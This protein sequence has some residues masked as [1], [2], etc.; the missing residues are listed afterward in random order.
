MK[1]NIFKKQV[2]DLENIV[3]TLKQQIQQYILINLAHIYI[4][5]VFL[6]KMTVKMVLEVQAGKSDA[7][8]TDSLRNTQDKM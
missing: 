4:L 8:T 3:L 6:L 2:L 7:F 5:L 1:L